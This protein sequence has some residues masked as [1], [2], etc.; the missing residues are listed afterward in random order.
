MAI[1]GWDTLQQA[2]LYTRQADRKRLARQ[3]MHL[4]V[5]PKNKQSA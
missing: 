1:Y 3:S 4:V 5:P 2:A